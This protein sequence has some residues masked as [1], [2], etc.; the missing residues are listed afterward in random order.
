[1]VSTKAGDG[2]LFLRTDGFDWDDF[3]FY[4]EV[5]ADFQ[6]LLELAESEKPSAQNNLSKLLVT[7]P[8]YPDNIYELQLN[9]FS[10]GTSLAAQA[11]A[12]APTSITST[13][14]L[15]GDTSNGVKVTASLSSVSTIQELID[16]VD[17]G[18]ETGE[19]ES[20]SIFDDGQEI[21]RIEFSRTEWSIKSD[22]MLISLTGQL[23]L[24][25]SEG[26]ELSKA[27][28]DASHI[29]TW[30]MGRN[31]PPEITDQRYNDLKQL[32]KQY[33]IDRFIIS[34]TGNFELEVALL[35][36]ELKFEFNELSF[37]IE[38]KFPTNF[39]DIFEIS[40]LMPSSSINAALS[41]Q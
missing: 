1:M 38:G 34:E 41:G 13:G 32:I 20:V 19:V 30:R 35:D 31:T 11:F 14:V 4:L 16:R 18:L 10:D 24:S 3:Y 2:R 37:S 39:D 22:D 6:T 8:T 33:D 17:S 26:I 7:E 9:A 25:L 23:P 40:A 21:L 15:W 29:Y 28:N 36:D 5:D 12:T 27:L